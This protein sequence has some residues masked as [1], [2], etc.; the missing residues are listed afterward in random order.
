MLG[1]M[2]KDY[3]LL[4]KEIIT[5]LFGIVGCSILLL[6]PWNKLSTDA[7]N[8]Q[9]LEFFVPV[10]TY[11]MIFIVISGIQINIFSLDERKN[12]SSFIMSTPIG[13]NGQV[14]SKYYEIILLSFSGVIYGYLCDIIASLISG[15]TKSTMMIYLTLFFVQ[16][17]LRAVDIP[18]Y[19][20]Y[21]QKYG[22]TIKIAMI[23]GFSF[24][25]IVYCLFGKLP[26]FTIDTM[27]ES[28][29]K[30]LA[31]TKA[32]SLTSLGIIAVFPY[33]TV[34]CFYISY[35]ISVKVYKKGVEVYEG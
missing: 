19:V 3:L 22:G 31:D 20:R 13:E 24:I 12:Y 26:D 6:I 5:S 2:Y 25:G 29:I 32:V 18:F 7:M 35:K 30:W 1:L 14:L 28:I 10:I 27:F 4:K 21:G 34:L 11:I 33:I 9:I 17:F 8:V 15:K 23:G 16:I